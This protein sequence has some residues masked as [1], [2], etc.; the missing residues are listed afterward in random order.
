[1]IPVAVKINQ[2]VINNFSQ[3]DFETFKTSSSKKQM[4]YKGRQYSVRGRIVR[5]FWAP[6]L[7]LEYQGPVLTLLA[8]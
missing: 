1:M 6:L 8:V 3:N 4:Q 7:L 2:G 5:K